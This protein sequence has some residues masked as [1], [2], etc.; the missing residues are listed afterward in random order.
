MTAA[1][2]YGTIC[3]PGAS[4]RTPASTVSW[5]VRAPATSCSGAPRCA[6]ETASPTAMSIGPPLLL[7][8]EGSV[9]AQVDDGFTGHP[10][11]RVGGLHRG[12]RVVDGLEVLDGRARVGCA[13]EPRAERFGVACGER[14]AGRL[15]ELEDGLGA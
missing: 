5:S 14:V 4:P 3:S 8:V 11:E 10:L 15:G 12:D 6:A 9:G 7:G 13:D 1:P 2:L